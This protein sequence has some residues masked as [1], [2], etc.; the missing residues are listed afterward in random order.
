MSKPVFI[1]EQDVLVLLGEA[2][3]IACRG[4]TNGQY[5]TR[6]QQRRNLDQSGTTGEQIIIILDST[7]QLQVNLAIELYSRPLAMQ[8]AWDGL[9]CHEL[10][11]LGLHGLIGIGFRNGTHFE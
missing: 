9:T 7:Y 2:S 11:G 1:E 6:Y 4:I 3:V 10:E 8:T 5:H